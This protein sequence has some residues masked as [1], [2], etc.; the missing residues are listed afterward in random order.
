MADSIRAVLFDLGGTLADYYDRAEWPAVL[1]ECIGAGLGFMRDRGLPVADP[2]AVRAS[3]E[4]EQQEEARRLKAGDWR[5]Y[6]MED[7]LA[8]A[9][10]PDGA[11]P[12]ARA[13]LCRAFLG[14]VFARGR[15]LP[16]APEAV[17]TVRARALA[18]AIVSNMPWGAPREPW[19]EEVRR[20][21]LLER[22]PTFLTCRDCGWRKPDGRIFALAAARLGV[23]PAACLFVGDEPV[24]DY[25]GA[26]DAGMR[27]VLLDRDGR[28]AVK[29]LTSIRDLSE[30][31]TLL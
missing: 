24:W 28:H 17:D 23:P 15:L 6:P 12:D 4:A 2:A 19:E 11:A 5:V 1:T 3:L 18:V 30:L 29:G 21:G 26:R 31:P 14:P 13:A 22:I 9:F 8:R 20:L 27:P 25:A 7:R 16:G 10:L